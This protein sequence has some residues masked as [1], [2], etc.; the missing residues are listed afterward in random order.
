MS[1]HASVLRSADSLD[2]AAQALTKLSVDRAPANLAGWEAT[3]LLTVASALVAAADRRQETRGCH[4]R[5]D[6]P[7]AS[8]V[9]RG[10]F[11]AGIDADGGIVETWEEA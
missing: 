5:D 6:F 11:L 9:Y 2:Q 1:T 3:N 7:D 4:W 8:D 10:H